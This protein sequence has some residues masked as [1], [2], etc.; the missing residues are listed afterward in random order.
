MMVPKR[1][2]LL[3]ILL[4]SF[5]GF[6]AAAR[7]QVV[8]KSAPVFGSEIEF[9][10]F[11]PAL[12]TQIRLDSA[13]GETG[14]EVEFEDDLGYADSKT[15]PYFQATWRVSKSWLVMVDYIDLDRSSSETIEKEIQWPPGEDGEVY[16]IGAK[17][18]SF[19]NFGS[20]RLAAAYIF[21]TSKKSELAV[22]FGFHLTQLSAGI[23]LALE[24]GGNVV[25]TEKDMELPII[26]LPTIGLY[27]GI[28]LS[29]KWIIRLRGD[30]FALTYDDYSGSL[31]STRAEA[32]YHFSTH[33]AAGGGLNG[34]KL[35]LE[36]EKPDFTGEAS[37]GY[38]GPSLF[39]RYLF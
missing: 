20:S 10:G 26:P 22:A 4:C 30:F 32:T 18:D 36:A 16:P 15:L 21:R 9:G 25:G 31:I 17:V 28:R 34:Y 2:I 19:F 3:P 24:G 38:W 35:S 11:W 33:W 37:L 8:K 27:W 14:T 1:T 29:D 6:Y 13:D 5:L 12:S 39:V 7:G 23:G